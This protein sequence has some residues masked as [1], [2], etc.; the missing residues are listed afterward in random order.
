MKKSC[1]LVV[2]LFLMYFSYG[3]ANSAIV[4]DQENDF[5]DGHVAFAIHNNQSIAQTFTVGQRGVLQQVEL[6]LSRQSTVTGNFSLSILSTSDGVPDGS[7]S[8][9]FSQSYPVTDIVVGTSTIEFLSFDVSSANILVSPGDMLALAITQDDNDWILWN[10][11]RSGY[12]SGNGFKG[13]GDL[14]TSW[15]LLNN[16]DYDLGFRTYVNTIP[17]PAAAWLFGSGLLGLIGVARR[18]KA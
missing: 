16:T 9:L 13:D 17:V 14:I 2:A 7:G 12:D 1:L 5:T 4:L 11:I 15:S 3:S 10:S 18:K 6:M 8:T